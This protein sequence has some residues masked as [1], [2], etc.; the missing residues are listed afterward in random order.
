MSA[1]SLKPVLGQSCGDMLWTLA[2]SFTGSAVNDL[3]IWRNDQKSYACKR[4]LAEAGYLLLVGAGAVETL[5]RAVCAIVLVPVLGITYFIA[6]YC[7][8]TLKSLSLWGVVQVTFSVLMTGS[9]TVDAAICL[10]KD[11][12]F[13]APISLNTMGKVGEFFQSYFPDEESESE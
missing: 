11:N 1:D 3:T 7:S 8:D 13:K 10:L 9:A 5:A 12:C 6:S 4:I 2:L